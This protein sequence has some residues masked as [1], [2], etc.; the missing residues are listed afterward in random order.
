MKPISK[1]DT[2]ITRRDAMKTGIGATS[3]ATLGS[4]AALPV[5]LSAASIGLVADAALAQ[6][7]RAP[8]TLPK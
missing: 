1:N 4:G 3:L 6:Q 5:A 8:Q 7:V 2:D